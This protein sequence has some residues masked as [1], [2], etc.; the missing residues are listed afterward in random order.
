MLFNFH[1][2]THLPVITASGTKLGRVHDI[3]FDIES[4]AIFGYCV[5]SSVIGR[6]YLI[7]PSQVV[8]ITNEKMVV[9]DAVSKTAIQPESQ[10]EKTGALAGVALTKEN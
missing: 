9:E 10:S 2:L 4:H 3:N 1:H 8:E 7:K 5:R 6:S